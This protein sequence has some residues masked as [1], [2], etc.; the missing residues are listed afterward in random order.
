MGRNGSHPDPVAASW[1][2]FAIELPFHGIGFERT[3]DS[4]RSVDLRPG[5]QIREVPP[6]ALAVAERNLP[7]PEVIEECGRV[8]I[9]V[10]PVVLESGQSMFATSQ[11]KAEKRGRWR[12]A[13]RPEPDRRPGDK[14][15]SRG[16]VNAERL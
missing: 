3:D 9:Q 6:Q 2:V 4:R 14:S 12:K 7:S 13:H 15:R 10:A 11:K 16:P 5:K 1:V 8:L